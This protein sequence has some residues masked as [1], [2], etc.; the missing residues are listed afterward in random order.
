M[1]VDPSRTSS[2]ASYRAH[3]PCAI[4]MHSSELYKESVPP[5]ISRNIKIFRAFV[6]AGVSS[7]SM[8]RRWR[9]PCSED[10]K[11]WRIKTQNADKWV[12]IGDR[13]KGSR[14]RIRIRNKEQ[15]EA[16][17]SMA[18]SP[19]FEKENRRGWGWKCPPDANH[20]DRIP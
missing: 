8:K 16:S 2:Y 11:G 18:P 14:I 13:K 6:S 5:R 9:T 4:A 12:R 10:S 17:R 7:L 3:Q 1:Y 19:R 20:N 15:R